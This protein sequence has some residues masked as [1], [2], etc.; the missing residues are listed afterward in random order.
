MSSSPYRESSVNPGFISRVG[1]TIA[2][3]FAA[4]AAV[5]VNYNNRSEDEARSVVT[6]SRQK[7]AKPLLSR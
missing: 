4:G 6:G 7:V 5:V 1:H 3:R 2:E